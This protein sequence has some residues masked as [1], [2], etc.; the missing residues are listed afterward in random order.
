[1][2]SEKVFRGQMNSIFN[3][4]NSHFVWLFKE[5]KVLYNGS[6]ILTFRHDNNHEVSTTIFF[7]SSK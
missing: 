4:P 7:R 3:I 6:K 1:M 5:W 2:F